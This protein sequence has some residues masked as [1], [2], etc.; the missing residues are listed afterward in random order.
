METD[1]YMSPSG[2]WHTPCTRRAIWINHKTGSNSVRSP[3][4]RAGAI[5]FIL[6]DITLRPLN[7]VGRSI[8][9]FAFRHRANLCTQVE[10]AHAKLFRR[11]FT[12]ATSR[13]RFEPYFHA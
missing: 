8:P 6:E 2:P 5:R 10:F 9:E 11:S 12:N 3:R 7:A 13:L 1:E 4:T